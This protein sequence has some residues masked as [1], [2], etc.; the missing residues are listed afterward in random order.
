VTER[1]TTDDDDWRIAAGLIRYPEDNDVVGVPI[2][3]VRRPLTS[4]EKLKHELIGLIM[5]QQA[6]DY[7]LTQGDAILWHDLDG[8]TKHIVLVPWDPIVRN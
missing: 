8:Q 1:N 4:D 6:A 5:M 3:A 2:D 7:P